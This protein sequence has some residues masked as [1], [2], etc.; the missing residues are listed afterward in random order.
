MKTILEKAFFAFLSEKFFFLMALL[1]GGI[2]SFIHWSS[3]SLFWTNI[4]K[5]C[6]ECKSGESGIPLF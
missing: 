6:R 3:E 5:T 2:F 4:V 1:R